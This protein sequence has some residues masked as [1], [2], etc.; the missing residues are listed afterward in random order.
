MRERAFFIFVLIPLLISAC[1]KPLGRYKI[2]DKILIREN[3]V[4][5]PGSNNNCELVAD[6]AAVVT[7]VEIHS[8]G[9]THP[10]DRLYIEPLFEEVFSCKNKEGLDKGYIYESSVRLYNP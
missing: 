2:N 6:T 8:E 10:E 5:N 1:G 9:S 3:R 7:F 4:I